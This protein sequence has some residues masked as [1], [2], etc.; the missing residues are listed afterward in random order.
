MCFLHEGERLAHFSQTYESESL[1]VWTMYVTREQL[2]YSKFH[3][4]VLVW[5]IQTKRNATNNW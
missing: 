3:T 2:A 4:K 5:I 1:P